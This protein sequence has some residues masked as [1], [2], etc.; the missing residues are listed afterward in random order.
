MKPIPFPQ[1]INW[2]Q[3]EY[4]NE[5][6]VFGIRKEK[7]FKPS[8][9]DIKLF[10]KKISTP[11][12]PSAGPCTQ[13]AQNILSCYLAGA[14]YIELK[15]VQALDGEELRKAVAKPSIN[16]DN[17]GYNVEWSTELTVK[18]A[19]EEYIKA[20]FL[21]HIFMV[22]FDISEENDFIFN[23]SIGYTLDG[24]KSEKI[25]SFIE[26]LKNAK[27]TEIWNSCYN[28]LAANIS[29]FA[30]FTKA[31]LD[32]I[33][34]EISTGI[35]ISTFYNC[36]SNEIE[37]IA[38][39]FLVEKKLNTYIKLNP[40][41]LGFNTS[42]ALLDEMGYENILFTDYHF[43]NDLQLNDA[44][45]MLR[46][47]QATAKKAQLGLGVKLTNTLPV[48]VIHNELPGTTMYLSG[49][50][51]FPLS[52]YTVKR[53]TDIFH[54]DMPIS[55]SGGVDYFNIR[56]ILAAGIKPVSMVTNLLKPGG[57][58]R[59]S[60]LAQ[61]AAQ[62]MVGSSLAEA[63]S[64]NIK[65]LNVLCENVTENGRYR[66][67]S[68]RAVSR[69]THYTLPLFDCTPIAPCKMDSPYCTRLDYD[70][71]IS[72]AAKAK[73]ALT[74]EPTAPESTDKKNKRPKDADNPK[75][76]LTSA[77]LK[78]GVIVEAQNDDADAERCLSCDTLCEI[79][80]DVCPNRA[81]VSV[82]LK[83]AEGKA[84][85]RQIVHIDS[86]C[87]ECGNCAVFCPYTG[88]PYKDKPVLFYDEENFNES[89]SAGFLKSGDN[90][91]TIRLEDGS[92]VKYKSGA[93]DIPPQWAALLDAILSKYKYLFPDIEK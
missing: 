48:G 78:K 6:S 5:G 80:I 56:E 70:D 66:K 26:G 86:I 82:A 69:K 75:T 7:F 46:H 65:A 43:N 91:Y 60:Q 85:S 55:F 14:R 67:D 93:K 32:A 24:I 13:L 71:P 34:P 58:Q 20:W 64:I 45:K 28:Y 41:L 15:T 90:V 72:T 47:L 35:T 50:A 79:C 8:A 89:E 23:I 49:R 57:I 2:V 27:N 17:E 39:Y 68:R 62:V 44:V 36:P 84:Q 63:R 1:L 88:K 87:N 16:A 42:R 19:M 38:T 12:G 29:S 31:D 11:I 81:N 54:G 21:C 59:L 61:I 74:N 3:S 76:L 92:V 52:L 10:V 73:Q 25:D 53:I 51:L 83:A 18:Q 30:K 33:S 9:C 37:K 77:Y 4:K 22:E 40:T